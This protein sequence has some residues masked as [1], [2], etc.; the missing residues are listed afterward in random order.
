VLA[1]AYKASKGGGILLTKNTAIDYALCNIR[2]NGVCPGYVETDLLKRCVEEACEDQKKFYE[3][4]IAFHP[5]RIARPEKIVYN[6]LYFSYRWRL[7]GSMRT[8]TAN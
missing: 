3:Q 1:P 6:W 2:V 5:I 4:V 8:C 7:Y